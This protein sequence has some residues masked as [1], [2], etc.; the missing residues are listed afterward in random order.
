MC[1]RFSFSRSHSAHSIQWK[2]ESYKYFPVWQHSD[3]IVYFV[4]GQVTRI[5]HTKQNTAAFTRMKGCRALKT[6]ACSFSAKILNNIILCSVAIHLTLSLIALEHWKRKVTHS[7]TF[8]H[9]H[10]LYISA[11]LYRGY[12]CY[13]LQISIAISHIFQQQRSTN[14]NNSIWNMASCVHLWCNAVDAP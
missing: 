14:T 11:I 4:I 12:S 6:Q 8:I 1:V 13:V 3:W 5:P 9:I 7:H 2:A 10:V